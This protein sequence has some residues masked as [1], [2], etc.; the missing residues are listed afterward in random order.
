MGLRPLGGRRKY[1]SGRIKKRHMKWKKKDYQ[2]D[3]KKEQG[4]FSA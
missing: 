2:S 4:K 3:G 1:G